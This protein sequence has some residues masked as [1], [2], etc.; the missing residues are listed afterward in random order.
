MLH[1][2]EFLI[3]LSPLKSLYSPRIVATAA[4]RGFESLTAHAQYSTLSGEPLPA[5][6][7]LPKL[8][9]TAFR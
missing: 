8:R 6:D 1:I 3:M 9:F 2:A 4:Q 7:Y 5:P